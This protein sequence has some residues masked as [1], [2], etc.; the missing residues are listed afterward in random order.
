MN[1]Q[2]NQEGASLIE[3]LVA[4]LI[5]SIG[6][7]GMVGLQ[8]RASQISTAAEDRT[9]AALLANDAASQMWGRMSVTLPTGDIN[10][11]RAR[12]QA[13]LPP[14]SSANP[15][16]DSTIAVSGSSA[17]ITIKWKPVQAKTATTNSCN[18]YTTTVVVL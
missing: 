11:W 10:D 6:V 15:D 16:S 14:C 17:V 18:S 8:A 2:R 5:F 3:V 9:T 13:A 12:V 1:S 4:L 7:L